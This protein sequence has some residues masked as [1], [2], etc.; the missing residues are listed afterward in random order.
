MTAKRKT[1]LDRVR[2]LC[3]ALP[4]TTEK[5]AWGAPTWRV[6]GKLFVMF[7]DHHH[8]DGRLAIW[9]NASDG[10]QEALVAAD[11][12]VFFRPAYVGPSGWIGVQLD[13]GLDWKVVKDLI[14]EAWKASA[15]KKVLKNAAI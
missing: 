10:A 11:P 5:I 6:G 8:N 13:K 14:A 4:E 1:P 9:C 7:A 2:E 12:D 3:L 15:P